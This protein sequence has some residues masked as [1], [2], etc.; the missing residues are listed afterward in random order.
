MTYQSDAVKLGKRAFQMVELHLPRCTR[1][2]GVAPC[3]AS[4]AGVEY[5]DSV[6]SYDDAT[7]VYDSAE[8]GSKKCFNT[9]ATCQDTDNFLPATVVYRFATGRIQGVQ[10][11]G[12]PPIFP[13]LSKV[14]TAATILTP[15]QGLG[16]RASVNCSIVDHP[17]TDIF[18]DPYLADRTYNPENQG[19]FWGRFLARNKYYLNRVLKVVTGFYEDDGETVDLASCYTRTYLISKISGP[20]ANGGVTIEAKD[21]LKLADGEKRQ[22]P[23]ASQAKLVATLT[24]GVFTFDVIDPAFQLSYMLV[25]GTL[26]LQPYIRIDSEIL[27][28][29]SAASLGPGLIQLTVS[30]GT[31]G[32]PSFYNVSLNLAAQ[33]EAGVVVQVCRLYDAVPV[34]T[35]VYELLRSGA[36]LDAAYLPVADW[37]TAMAG[38]GWTFSA[39]LEG[40][41]PVKDLLA[42]ITRL[43]VLI[44]WDDRSAAVQMKPL[45][46]QE[47][48][49]PEIRDD[50]AIIAES[51]KVTD[52]VSKL[53]TESWIYFGE[54]TPVGNRKLLQSYR[55]LNIA[56][57]T[58]A[59]SPNAYGS[60]QILEVRTRWIPLSN[61]AMAASI[62]ATNIRQYNTVRK[63]IT[64]RLDPKDDLFYIGDVI[65]ISTRYVQNDEGEAESRNYL[66]VEAK[67]VMGDGLSYT[68]VATEQFSF[69]RVGVITHPNGDGSEP[70]PGPPP[71]YSAASIAEKNQWA[72]ISR[73]TADFADGTTAYQI[74]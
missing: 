32:I 37:T 25:P 47:T 50:N 39:L 16:V 52:D 64:F 1:T 51:V 60:P 61:P 67:E 56:I 10:E 44:W 35:A 31:A 70:P 68:Y 20:G 15:G 71:D 8:T 4:L 57:D 5:D 13:T 26:A 18:T 36:A 41:T 46:F 17:W 74:V 7:I 19:T 42:E 30:R 14:D 28:V 40:P 38:L 24:V 12:E 45:R 59:E 21:P 22:W 58:D 63:A 27:K 34:Q 2:Y 49:V 62:N 69:S 54:A 53:A 55:A 23:V 33:H 9:F 11:P 3:M 29:T 6:T 65:G 66:I 43:G 48:L 73:N 72:Y